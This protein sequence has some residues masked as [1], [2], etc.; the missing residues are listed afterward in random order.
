MGKS[1]QALHLG[2]DQ[3]L[4]ELVE[5]E[6]AEGKDE[7]AQDVDDGNTGGE[8]GGCKPGQQRPAQR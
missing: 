1:S 7:K 8:A 6:D 4:A 2:V 5:I 3:S